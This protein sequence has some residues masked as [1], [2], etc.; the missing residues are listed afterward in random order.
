MISFDMNANNQ[1]VYKI[2]QSLQ[3]ILDRKKYLMLNF[4]Q[5]SASSCNRQCYKRIER[6]VVEQR[7]VHPPM[8]LHMAQHV[9]ASVLNCID[10][11]MTN[12]SYPLKCTLFSETDLPSSSISL[13]GRFT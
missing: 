11:F 12:P 4:P 6:Y 13:L 10:N 3:L 9:F 8:P 7:G 2:F 1:K 5:F